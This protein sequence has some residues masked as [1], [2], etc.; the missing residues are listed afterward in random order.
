MQKP[1]S[2]PSLRHVALLVQNFSECARF[3]TEILG[4]TIEWQPDDDNLYL[5]FGSDNLA[6]HRAKS[7]ITWS[8]QQRLD[9]MGFMLKAPEDVDAWYTYL[10]ACQVPI[11]Q[12]P[13]NHRDGARSFYCLDPDGNGVQIM[14]HPPISN[15]LRVE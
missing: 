2:K 14:Y 13:R 5:T 4:M 10:Q 6:L 8:P 15:T 12:A 3:Y 9:H 11:K 1:Q 7:D